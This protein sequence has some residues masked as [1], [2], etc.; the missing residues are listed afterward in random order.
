MNLIKSNNNYYLA[1]SS[2]KYYGI[3]GNDYTIVNGKLIWANSNIYLQNDAKNYIDMEYVPKKNSAIIVDF[4]VDNVRDI[5]SSTRNWICGGEAVYAQPGNFYAGFWFIGTTASDSRFWLNTTNL[6]S[7]NTGTV[8]SGDFILYKYRLI[9]TSPYNINYRNTNNNGSFSYIKQIDTDTNIRTMNN[10][11][12]NWGDFSQSI[13]LFNRTY[14][15]NSSTAFLL[16]RIYKAEIWEDNNL[17][18]KFIPVPTNLQI[19][20]YTVP[21]NGMFDIVH[22]QFFPNQGTGTFTYGKDS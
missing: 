21:S 18:K 22:Q 8:S 5:A 15:L 11:E 20:S 1:K 2:N 9:L 16:G 4:K 7:G 12:V 17:I 13:V 10:L 3:Q 6:G 14:S 19:G